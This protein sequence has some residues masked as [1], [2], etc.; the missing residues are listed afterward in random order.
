MQ[1]G[2]TAGMKHDFAAIAAHIEEYLPLRAG[3]MILSGTPG[4]T[5]ME[6]GPDGDRWLQDGDV[7]EVEVGAAG[8]LR[9]TVAR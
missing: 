3:D 1:E 2:S 7:T 8:V 4:G 5:A 9:N 6:Y